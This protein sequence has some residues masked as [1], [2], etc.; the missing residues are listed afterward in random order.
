MSVAKFRKYPFIRKLVD[1]SPILLMNGTDILED[2]MM[3]ARVTR[4]DLFSKL[5]ESNVTQFSQIKAVIME[6]TGDISVLHYKDPEHEIDE[7]IL[8]NVRFK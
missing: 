4:E 8:E 3:E 6:T 7:V 5:R 2:N 1:N